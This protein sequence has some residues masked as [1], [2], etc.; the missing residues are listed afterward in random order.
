MT[1]LLYWSIGNSSELYCMYTHILVLFQSDDLHNAYSV[2]SP[3]N[4][5]N[6]IRRVSYPT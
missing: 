6:N 5:V 1:I 3:Y 2:F 4:F